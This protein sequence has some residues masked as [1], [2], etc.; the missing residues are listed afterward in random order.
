MRRMLRLTNDLLDASR[1]D[2]GTFSVLPCATV[3][4]DALVTEA[5]EAFQ[6]QAVAQGVELIVDPIAPLSIRCD[7]DRVHQVLSNLLGN[8]LKFTGAGGRVRVS[9]V[10]SG[11][12]ALF[13]VADSGPGIS[14][15]NQPHVFDR[16]WQANEAKYL[17]A[18]LGL[19]IAKGLVEAQGGRIYVES[20][21]G[22]GTRMCFTI[23][24]ATDV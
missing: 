10:E 5:T 18:G 23:P 8:A 7:P 14:S 12:L 9:V 22:K 2:A 11:T 4:A 3:R 16:S 15:E 1:I 19:F 13:C 20:E 17:G 21:P 24:L 6:D